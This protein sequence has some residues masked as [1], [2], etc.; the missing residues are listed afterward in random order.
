V[1]TV[2]ELEQRAVEL[3][4]RLI[5]FN[6][7]NP[8]GN[9]RAAQEFLKELLEG[10]GFAVELVGAQ[11]ERPNLIAT[12]PGGS[13][14]PTLTYLGHVDT[15]LAEAGDW[16]VDPWSGELRDD[17]V[18]GRGAFDMK[19]QVASEIAAVCA[20][21]ADGWRPESGELKVIVTADEETGAALGA[22][23]LC[24]NVPDK[25]RS[26]FVVNE[27]GGSSFEFDGRRVYT[28]G[29]AEKGVFRFSISTPGRAGHASMPRIGDN[30]LTKLAPFLEAFAH[31]RATFDRSR[32]PVAFLES[33]GI[34]TA[35]LEDALAEAERRE[36]RLGA[37]LEPTLGVTF[38]PT[39]ISAS[40]KINVIPGRATLKVDCRVPPELGQD[41]ARVRIGEVLGNHD[42]YE[43]RFD[44][45]VVGNRSA[46]ETPLMDH[47]REFVESED[48]GSAIAPSVLPGFTDSRWFRDAFPECVAYGFCPHRA[49][50]MFEE[51]ALM[52]SVDERVRVEDLGMAA[53][54]YAELAPKVLA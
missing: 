36:P 38:A 34:D 32:E 12:L 27:G 4:Q 16:T 47:V 8:P 52:H 41:H 17:C 22:Q 33:L 25:V 14:G 49:M 23:W 3:L 18:W 37:V 28:V 2:P 42:G 20:L 1:R 10:A 35:E 6:T 43:L 40:E 21:C 51:N 46:V 26:D 39:M 15:V 45:Q 11:D 54:F 53:R 50:D 30:A 19:G 44:E 48:P 13:D 29:V 7:V 31:R 9:E 5:R 24:A